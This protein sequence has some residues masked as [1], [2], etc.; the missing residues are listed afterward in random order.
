M[1]KTICDLCGT[2]DNAAGTLWWKSGPWAGS[3]R[4]KDICQTCLNNVLHY[5]ETLKP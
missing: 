5:M 3:Q 1:K 4:S 2:E